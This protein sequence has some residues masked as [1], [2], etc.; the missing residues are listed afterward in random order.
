MSAVPIT[1]QQ[2]IFTFVWYTVELLANIAVIY[3]VL[4][5]SG[6]VKPVRLV[7][8]DVPTAMN[9]TWSQTGSLINNAVGIAKKVNDALNNPQEEETK[10]KKTRGEGKEAK[11]ETKS[12]STKKKDDE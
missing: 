9:D 12:K 4:L 3:Y 7:K 5:T 1:Y 8:N 6:W 11:T 2:T 10:G